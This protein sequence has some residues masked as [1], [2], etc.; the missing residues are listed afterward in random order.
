VEVHNK[1][2][3]NYKVYKVCNYKVYQIWMTKFAK[4][5]ITKFVF[6]KLLIIKNLLAYSQSWFSQTSYLQ[7]SC[8]PSLCSQSSCPQ[9]LPLRRSTKWSFNCNVQI[10]KN[11]YYEDWNYKVCNCEIRDYKVCNCEVCNFVIAKF[12][13][14][15]F[16]TISKGRI[17]FNSG[18]QTAEQF[19]WQQ[20]SWLAVRT[21][22]LAKTSGLAD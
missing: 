6:T 14:M 17:F 7:S 16:I 10:C 15:K 1:K 4:F 19:L 13:I 8:S 9:R 22:L 11:H 5:V 18:I 21:A 20:T 2:I 3:C 12:V